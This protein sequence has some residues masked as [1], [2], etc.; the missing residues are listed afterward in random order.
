VRRFTRL[1]LSL[2]AVTSLFA[3]GLNIQSATAKKAKPIPSPKP[4]WPPAGFDGHDGVYAKVP[5]R[6]EL[7][8]E[9]SDRPS[10][11]RQINFCKENSLACASVTVAAQRGCAWWEVNSAVRR[12]DPNT[13]KKVK[14]GSLVT[15]ARGTDPEIRLTIMLISQ[16][17][18]DPSV[19][20]GNMKVICHPSSDARPKLG[21]IYNPIA[22]DGS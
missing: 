14:I 5:T 13:A 3:T 8:G 16:E 17:S 22:S 20:I 18:A 4:A 1:V 7:I 12:L 11:S 10:L 21:N 9:A 15:Y 2:L 19:S 6:K